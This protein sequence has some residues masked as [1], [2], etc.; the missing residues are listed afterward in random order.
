MSATFNCCARCVVCCFIRPL[1][2]VTVITRS[3]I[4]VDF[5]FDISNIFLSRQWQLR[6]NCSMTISHSPYYMLTSTTL[7]QMK[8]IEPFG[9]VSNLLVCWLLL[10]V[11]NDRTT[12]NL[13]AFFIDFKLREISPLPKF[14]AR[15]TKKKRNS[16]HTATTHRM[17]FFELHFFSLLIHR[18]SSLSLSL[19]EPRRVCCLSM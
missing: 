1:N 5:L 10:I 7:L 17:W 14:Q 9:F 6:S 3:P 15:A 19:C 4:C 2:L 11:T 13:H 16:S 12:T 18:F 8:F